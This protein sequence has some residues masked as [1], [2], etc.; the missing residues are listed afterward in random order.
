MDEQK[1]EILVIFPDIDRPYTLLVSSIGK[2]QIFEVPEEAM[3]QSMRDG[4]MDYVGMSLGHDATFE[5]AREEISQRLKP[6]ELPELEL[7]GLMIQAMFRFL[8]Q[9]DVEHG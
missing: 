1:E 8:M 6:V 5:M 9:K 3:R 7:R 2:I 4:L